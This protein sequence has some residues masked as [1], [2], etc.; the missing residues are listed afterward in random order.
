VAVY[1]SET[2]EETGDKKEVM[3]GRGVTPFVS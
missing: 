3:R 2:K 1:K